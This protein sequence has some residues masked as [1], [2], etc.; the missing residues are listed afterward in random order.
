M[1]V[2]LEF[3]TCNPIARTHK[4]GRLAI[5]HSLGTDAVSS[6]LNKQINIVSVMSI[7][8]VWN[9]RQHRS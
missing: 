1:K 6:L 7:F 3:V 4:K 9:Y 2:S 5:K 8:Y